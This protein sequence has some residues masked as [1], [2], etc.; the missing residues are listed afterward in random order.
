[1]KRLDKVAAKLKAD[2]DLPLV[3]VFI[4][5]IVLA[6]G[7]TKDGADN[8]TAT[9]NVVLRTMAELATRA[10]CFVF[11]IDHFGK[12]VNVGTRGNSVKEG[13]ADVVLALLGDRAI[14]GEISS[15]KLAIRKRRGGANGQEFPF[16]PQ[17]VDMGADQHGKPVTTLVLDWGVTAEPPKGRKDNWGKGGGKLLRQIVMGLLAECGVDLKPFADGPMVK[18]LEVERVRAEFFKRRYTEGD[19]EKAKRQAK[20]MAFQ[21]AM[22]AAVDRGVIATREVEGVEY[23]WLTSAHA[24]THAHAKG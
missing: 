14:T 8:D 5:T 2:F 17:T 19:S 11:G 22:E 3:A 7:Y 23:V 13:N 15:T 24:E 6:A 10:G 18:A 16:R 4:D 9:T 21:R 20:R 12:D 1:M